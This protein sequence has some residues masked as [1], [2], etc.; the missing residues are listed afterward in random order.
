MMRRRVAN[1]IGIDA[2]MDDSGRGER[3]GAEGKSSSNKDPKPMVS[4]VS[5]FI[6]VAIFVALGKLQHQYN[7][8][9]SADPFGNSRMMDRI[10]ASS[11]KQKPH[12]LPSNIVKYSLL[13]DTENGSLEYDKDGIRYH[14][15]FST[16]CSPYQHWQSYLVYYTAMKIRQPGHVTRIAS[17]CGDDEAAAMQDWFNSEVKFMS[18]KRFHLQLTPH[19]SGITNSDTG[20]V[21]GDYK[22]FNKPRGFKYWLENSPQLQFDADS[23]VFPE[24]VR[25]DIAILIDPDM[26]LLRPITRDFSVERETLVGPRRKDRMIATKVGPGKPFAQVYGFGAQWARLNLTAI[27]GDETP[28]A[29]VSHDDVLMYY[30]VGPPYLGT[31]EDM[32]AIATKW[33]E[34]VPHVYEVNYWM[35]DFR[36]PCTIFVFMT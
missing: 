8:S 23:G 30:P 11:E 26:G 7:T 5:L 2:G 4:N 16:D 33:S 31:I 22:F 34:F 28:A 36:K 29:N 18:P 1:G 6:V 25:H 10:P 35:I 12:A 15:V 19:F 24:D 17:G 14:V 3:R 21:T 27:A 13:S 32:Y 9:R 20:E